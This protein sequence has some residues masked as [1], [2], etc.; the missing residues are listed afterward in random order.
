MI[1][2]LSGAA[3]TLAY[4]FMAYSYQLSAGGS[5]SSFWFE[6][7]IFWAPNACMLL[8]FAFLR[9]GGVLA[10]SVLALATIAQLGEAPADLRG[11]PQLVS[12]LIMLVGGPLALVRA[13][14]VYRRRKN[15]SMKAP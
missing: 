9:A 15:T 1:V 6:L 4:A 5:R 3:W 11:T 8:T 10:F 12:M 7:V 14:S 13:D 2:Q